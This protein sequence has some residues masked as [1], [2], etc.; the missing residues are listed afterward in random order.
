MPNYAKIDEKDFVFIPC[1]PSEQERKEISDF[2][3]KDKAQ[4]KSLKRITLPAEKK[5]GKPD[6]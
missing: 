1:T 2:I 5:T 3:R 6:R 4:Q